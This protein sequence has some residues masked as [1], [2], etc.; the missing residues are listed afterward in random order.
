[1]YVNRDV[2]LTI[3]FWDNKPPEGT[4]YWSVQRECQNVSLLEMMR[5]AI[6]NS[7]DPI[8]LHP[9]PQ[10]YRDALANLHAF[11]DEGRER[12][13]FRDT[14]GA[15]EYNTPPRVKRCYGWMM[16]S[17]QELCTL[18]L[19]MRALEVRLDGAVRD[20]SPSEDYHAI[21][22]EYI[23]DNGC[24]FS[25]EVVQAQLDFFWLAGFCLVPS[26]VENWRGTG[27]LVDM[28]DLVCPWHIPWHPMLYGPRRAAGLCDGTRTG[29]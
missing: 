27:I 14:P 9:Q 2:L 28:A 17:G 11:S 5:F 21:V 7:S 29:A 22:Y 8:R 26:P 3:K 23:S 15:I 24:T 19:R 4:R 10:K 16:I 20:I 18:P 25:P 6:E 13:S 1:M 12:Q